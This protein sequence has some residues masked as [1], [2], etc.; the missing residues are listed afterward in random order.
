M[1]RT[2]AHPV[3]KANFRKQ[4]FLDVTLDTYSPLDI[5]KQ[6]VYHPTMIRSFRCT[7]TE[8][9]FHREFSRKFPGDI[10]EWAFMKLN[11][12]DAAVTI[13]DLRLP[14]SNRL[15][16]LKGDRKGQ[17]SIRINDQWRIC[18]EW[19]EGNAENVEIG[20]YH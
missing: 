4:P 17:R 9:I 20:D 10:Q 12:L 3:E 5:N 16:A 11:A 1:G 14:P 6:N 8:K 19:S 18:F 7:E 13:Q 15:E 2:I